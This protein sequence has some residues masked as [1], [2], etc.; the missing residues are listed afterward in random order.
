MIFEDP[1]T[2]IEEEII[3]LKEEGY[4]T[5]DLQDSYEW[6]LIEHGQ[7]TWTDAKH[8][9]YEYEND[10]LEKQTNFAYFEPS[11]LETILK[12]SNLSGYNVAPLKMNDDLLFDKIYGAF[13][14]RA[15]GCILG[16]PVEGWKRSEI[17]SYLSNAGEQ[18]LSFYFP[19]QFY[20]K[21][22]NRF[23]GCFRE[24]IKMAVRDDD[25]DYPI[26]NLKVLENYGYDF[27]TANVGKIWLENLPFGAVYT[28]ERAAYRNLI[29][30]IQPPKTAT[31]MNPYR[32]WIG[33]QIRGDIF[34]WISPGNP[35]KASQLAYKDARLSHVKNGIYGEMFISALLAHAYIYK[36]PI[37]LVL[38]SLK[39][40]PQ[41]SRLYEAIMSTVDIYSK[42]I[43]FEDA[44]HIISSKYNYNW[45][46]TI[47]NAC[48]VVLSLLYGGGDFERS[49]CYA[50]ECG[51]DTDCNGATVGSIVGLMKGAKDLP[52][53]WI[54]P[55]NDTLQSF[56]PGFNII[57]ISDLAR[58]IVDLAKNNSIS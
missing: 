11:D 20:P 25:L 34:G 37:Q 12:E 8:F 51:S 31:F 23:D 49:I 5:S 6:F 26:I 27:S 58:R 13:L 10:S 45:I 22:D 33:A 2:L 56:V 46:H 40:I 48:F 43:K 7:I 18:K 44:W 57:R 42:G 36:D 19:K 1:K 54:K 53:N 3:Q 50:V 24:D 14:G 16:K 55:L 15:S 30:S 21:S 9:F 47:N 17:L 41:K 38:N 52:T 35:S 4:S 28:A 32:E 29:M 39:Y